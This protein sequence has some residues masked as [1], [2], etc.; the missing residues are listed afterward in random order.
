MWKA[1]TPGAVHEMLFVHG[2]GAV[3][4]YWELKSP[5]STAI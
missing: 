4:A 2:A 3:N 1:A 5:F